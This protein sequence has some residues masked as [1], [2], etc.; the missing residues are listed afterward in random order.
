MKNIQRDS[1][2]GGPEVKGRH[3]LTA[4]GSRFA[5]TA[6]FGLIAAGICAAPVIAPVHIPG[7]ET[8]DL[9]ATALLLCG[10]V[11]LLLEIKI[12]TNG[13]LAFVGTLLVM[14]AG[15]VIWGEGGLFWGIPFVYI[16][17]FLVVWIIIS[18]GLA[19]LGAQAH[20]QKVSSGSEGFTGELAQAS[21]ALQPSGRVY[22]QGTYWQAVSTS[23]V[24][25]GQA[26][27][28]TGVDKLTLL[29]E[30]ATKLPSDKGE[31]AQAPH[32]P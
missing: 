17:P 10:A 20:R 19:V 23:P 26:V 1:L 21:E 7:N 29:V 12:T 13:V 18:L 24:A 3:R 16:V 25:A 15:G 32:Q 4:Y 31:F 2:Q 5:A 14:L 28:I 11:L 6:V 30:P 27:R 22:F 9:A 8:P